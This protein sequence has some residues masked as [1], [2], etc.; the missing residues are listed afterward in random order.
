MKRLRIAGTDL[1][2]ACLCQSAAPFGT[3]V[4][5]ADMD[6][7]YEAYRSAGGNFFD[8]AHCYCFW[9]KDGNGASERALGDC[10]RR[11]GDRSQVII[12]TKGGNPAVP[13]Q[14]PHPAAYL[15]PEAIAVDVQESLE[16]LG[17][18]QIDLYYLHRDDPRV[19]V[20]EIMDTLNAEVKRGRLRYLG[21]SNWSTTRIAAANAYAAE[22]GQPGF[23]VSQ[24][25]WNLAQPNPGGDPTMQF[26]SAEDEAWHTRHQ[27]PVVA[28][29][30][31]ACGYFACQGD[32]AGR[33]FDNPISRV[34]HQRARQ[35]A[36][37]L[38][39]TPNQIALAWLL[40]QPF[41]VIPILGTTKLDHQADALASTTVQLTA[42]QVRWLQS[43]TPLAPTNS[44]VV[45]NER[46]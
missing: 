41:P 14:Y 38:G 30:P 16:R 6:R 22:R 2:L 17:V 8:T 42:E 35:L 39:V 4:R 36:A 15:A 45:G 13:P 25:Q 29:S 33:Q 7:L 1:K 26:V 10:L 37:E 9:L 43:T 23:V 27:L 18:D 44:K 24:P 46:A 34:R 3:A 20:G 19:P 12:G 28:Y 32:L 5:G 31:T 21:A 40:A 11:H